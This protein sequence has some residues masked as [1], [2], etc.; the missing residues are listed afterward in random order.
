MKGKAKFFRILSWLIL[1]HPMLVE[2][3]PLHWASES[4][5]F[6]GGLFHLLTSPEH[7]LA[8][9]LIGMC[10]ARG[11]RRMI[12][13]MP[14]MYVVL[15]LVGAGLA[16]FSIELSYVESAASLSLLTLAV[17]LV[18]GNRSLLPV[19]M[20]I[21][22]NLA[23]L[24]GYIHAYDMMLD[25]DAAFFSVGF[26]LGAL[27]LIVAGSGLRRVLERFELPYVQQAVER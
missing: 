1:V 26:V 14:I 20:L 10:M 27:L 21:V 3:H 11:G 7:V 25:A 23:V 17:M 13:V 24:D 12:N 9:I 6:W 4:L 8:L 5:G 16:L 18:L 22:A 2:A 19:M 15:M